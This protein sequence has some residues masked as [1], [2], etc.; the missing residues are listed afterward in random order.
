MKNQTVLSQDTSDAFEARQPE[1][2]TLFF[3]CH[4]QGFI[5]HPVRP[6]IVITDEVL[7]ICLEQTSHGRMKTGNASLVPHFVNGL[8]RDYGIESAE[9]RRPARVFKA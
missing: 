4:V 8:H 6:D 9:R 3:N 7:P 2:I 5:F 1:R